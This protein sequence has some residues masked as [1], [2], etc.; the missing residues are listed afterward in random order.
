MTI[1][2]IIYNSTTG[3]ISGNG[4]GQPAPVDRSDYIEDGVLN[5]ESYQAAIATAKSEFLTAVAKTGYSAIE[6]SANPRT[7]KVNVSTKALVSY[8]PV[9]NTDWGAYNRKIRDNL[10]RG[11]DWTQFT[12]SPLTATKKSEWA[13]YRQDL[14]DLPEDVDD[15]ET[16]KMSTSDLPTEPS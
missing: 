10:L 16:A 9:D 1:H 14:R 13:T 11:S 15:F 12:D 5:Q 7:Q 6:G 3:I 4:S 2:Y 8:T